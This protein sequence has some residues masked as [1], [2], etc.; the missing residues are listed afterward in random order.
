LPQDKKLARDV[1]G[2]AYLD[3]DCNLVANVS[4]INHKK[5]TPQEAF[6]AWIGDL[7]TCYQLLNG[8]DD[9]VL[10]YIQAIA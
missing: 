4:D 8:D 6:F 9:T 1:I 10:R 2:L 3:D 5:D 7:Q